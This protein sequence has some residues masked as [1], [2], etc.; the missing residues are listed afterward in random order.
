MKIG[1]ILLT[2]NECYKVGQKIKPIGI[3]VHSTGANNTELRRYIAPDDGII[4]K[5]QYNNHWNQLRPSGR[6]V[7]VHGFIGTDKN[8][9]IRAYQTLPWDMRGWHAGSGA[10][11]SANDGYVSFEICEDS[12][13]NK[14]YAVETYNMAVELCAHLKKLYPTIKI[15]NIIGHYEAAAKGIAS[16]HGD[17]QHWW[18]KHGLT[19]EQFRKDVQKKVEPAPAPDKGDTMELWRIKAGAEI[20]QDPPLTV[21]KAGAYTIVE[22]RGDWGK[23][24]SGAG[25]INLTKAEYIRKI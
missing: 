19:M 1:K 10:K 11:G 17:P 7:C 4:G 23:L 25:W 3:V 6:Q 9:V 8:G 15:E 16:N 14:A 22:K 2:K 20:K 13:N 24:K 18:K 5:N 21:D 12:T